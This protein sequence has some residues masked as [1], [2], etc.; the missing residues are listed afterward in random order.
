[1]GARAVLRYIARWNGRLAVVDASPEFLPQD[2]P[3]A[4]TPAPAAAAAPLTHGMR[5]ACARARALFA[6][7]LLRV[8]AAAAEV[9]AAL[10]LLP[11][12][13]GVTV[14]AQALQ[15]TR[16]TVAL[17]NNSAPLA[18]SLAPQPSVNAAP[19]AGPP[20]SATSFTPGEVVAGGSNR[21]ITGRT[22]TSTRSVRWLES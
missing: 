10:Q 11:G 15:N 3:L 13:R 21:K 18:V 4:P 7:P 22:R 12:A 2:A 6:P 9:Q 20:F 17:P 14:R 19:D 16:L 8:T 5:A 1:V